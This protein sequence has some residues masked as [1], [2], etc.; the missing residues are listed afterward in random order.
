MI[1]N[2]LSVSEHNFSSLGLFKL[3]K[4]VSVTD[5]ANIILDIRV[6]IDLM[7]WVEIYL[8]CGMSAN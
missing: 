8:C 7:K 3:F 1:E 4:V 5:M 2:K 6:G